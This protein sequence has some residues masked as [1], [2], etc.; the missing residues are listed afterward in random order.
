VPGSRNA[1]PWTAE[2]EVTVVCLC[3]EVFIGVRTLEYVTK[4]GCSGRVHL[5]RVQFCL[6]TCETL[7]VSVEQ[8]VSSTWGLEGVGAPFDLRRQ[9]RWKHF[10]IPFPPGFYNISEGNIIPPDALCSPP[11]PCAT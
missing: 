11:L 6:A 5:L 2:S 3:S 4:N 10:I 9:Y 1:T 7:L 8:V